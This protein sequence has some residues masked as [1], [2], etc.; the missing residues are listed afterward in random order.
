MDISKYD[1]LHEI[2]RHG[3]FVVYR[4]CRR[5]DRLPVLLQAPYRIPVALADREALERQFELIGGLVI[6]GI[7]KVYDLVRDNDRTYLVFEDAGFTPL[8]ALLQRGALDLALF[9]K[10]A[11]GLCSIV[12]DLHRRQLTHGA[13]GTGSVLVDPDSG[14]VQLLNTGLVPSTAVE[15]GRQASIAPAAYMSP[16]QTGRM[17]RPVDYRTDLY[18]LGITLYEALTAGRPFTSDDSLELIHAHIARTPTA[19]SALNPTVPEQLSRIVLKLLAKAAEHR[20]Q[21][22]P[23][24]KHD[25]ER[26]RE[27][28]EAT[29]AIAAFPPGQQD[30]PGRFLISQK[31]YGRDREVA[32]LLRAFE[33]TCEGPAALM[34]VSGYSGIG[35]TSLIHELYKPIVRQRGYFISGKFDQV[36][37]NIP[38]SGFTQA[39][40]GLV[41]QLLTESEDR[42]AQWRVRLS[43]AL[44]SNGGVLADV[45]PEVELILGRQAP[46]PPLDPAEAS[47]RFGYVFQSFVSALAQPEHPLVVFLDD[48]QWVDAATL[49]LL[50]ALLTGPDV[51]H[52]LIIGAYRDNEVDAGHL[53][54]RAIDRLDA[55]G[56]HLSRLSLA[57]LALPDLSSF[58]CDTL[59]RERPSIEPLA[60]LIQSKTDGNPFFVIQFL[61]T[62]EQEGHFTFAGERAGW[63]FDMAALAAAGMTDNVVD[64]MTRKIRRLSPSAQRVVTLAACVGNQF[65]W[66]TFVTVSRQSP[67]EAATGLAE[68][69][70]AG[71]VQ[72]LED[73]SRPAGGTASLYAFIHDRVQQA[74]YGLIPDEQKKP[75]HLDVGRL[76]LA[77]FDPTR[78]DD[79]IFTI[80]NHLNTGSDLITSAAERLSLAELNLSGGRKAKTSAAY[81]AAVE[82]S[83]KGVALLQ[84]SEWGSHYDLAF[85]LHL[86]RA[87]CLYLAGNFDLAHTAF[88]LPLEHAA[89]PLDRAQVHSLRIRL[90]ENQSRWADAV[91]AARDGLRLFDIAFPEDADGKQTALDREVGAVQ[92][93]LGSRA[94]ASLV[95]LPEMTDPDMQMVM[96]L[97]TS[98]WAPAYISG[99][100]ILARLI[101]AEMVRLSLAYGNTEDSA[102]GYVTH[103]IT[104]GPIRRDYRSAYEWG[105]LALSVNRRFGDVKRRAKI[106][107]QF[108]AHVN[109]WRRPFDTCIPHA[110]EAYRSGLESGDFAYAGYGA[111]TEAWSAWLINRDID[112]FVREFLPTLA[113]LEKTKMGDFWVAHR[114]ILNWA[115]ALEGRTSA[116]LSLSDATFD[117][118]RF[119]QK[120]EA[121]APFFLTFLYTAKLHLSVLYEDYGLA[122]TAAAAA[123]QAAVTGTIWPVLIDF[124]GGLAVAGIFHSASEEDQ[125]RY[126]TQLLTVQQSLAELA[127]ACPEN[128][129]GFALLISAEILRLKASPEEATTLYEEAIAWARQTS[130]LQQAALANDLCARMWL[131]QEDD[132]RATPFVRAAYQ[133]YAEW[134]ASAKLAHLEERYGRLLPGSMR[135][136]V[137]IRAPIGQTTRIEETDADLSTVLKVAH[138]IAVEIE[139]GGLLRKLMKLALEN[140][141]AQRGAFLHERDGRLV[142]EAAADADR[143]LV[144]VGPLVSLDEAHDLAVTVVRYVH[145]TRQ[146]VVIAN[147]AVDERFAGDPYVARSDAKSILCVP[148]GHQGRLGGILYLENSLTTDA[149]TP[150]RIAMMRILAAQTAISLETARLYDDM[151]DEVGRRTAA[152]RALRDALSE[153]EALKNRLEAENVYLQE[154]IQTQHNFNEIVGNSPPLVEALRQVERVAPTESTVLIVGETGSGKE[155]FARAVHSRSLRRNRPLV[156]V[157]CGAI[158]PGLV[159]SELFGHVKGAFTGAIEKRIGRFE[160]AHGGTIFLDEIGDLPLDAQVKLLRVLQEQEFEPVGSSRT[161]R[162]SVRV[163]AATNRD[164]DQAVR[165]GRFRTDLLYRL[166][167]FPIEVPPLRQRASDIGLLAGFFATA[168]ARRLGKPLQGFSARSMERMERYAWPGNI[169]ELQNVVE[170]AAILARGP[171]LEIESPLLGAGPGTPDVPA[172]VDA[173]PRGDSLDDVQRLHILEV[174]KITGGVVEGARGAATILGLHPNTLRSRMKRLGIATAS[175]HAS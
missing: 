58:L 80:I 125:R 102:Y 135:V 49:D 13:V 12:D 166:N 145:R 29:G 48:L 92:A 88:R 18:S 113:M 9:F 136:G 105:E 42:L 8:P 20:Y 38:Y 87:E 146:D 34:L 93:L 74:A 106:H 85:S 129:R 140:A 89:T 10:V 75:V 54:T 68:A 25:L 148:V 63:S 152:E 139:V 46:P 91:S 172:P 107:Q 40:R 83:E 59:H 81:G 144:T 143:E 61:K 79:R 124:W 35:K 5:S 153:V 62:L 78:P 96:R 147:A 95:E 99:D 77:D 130:N 159:E 109:L 37:R 15:A 174:L 108:Q 90:Y 7:P 23:G 127:D 51:R 160:L 26:C 101:S 133:A 115:L 55:S 168:I 50:H 31:L 84:P 72:E 30:L 67:G 17:N 41:W 73:P 173:P 110:R 134:G 117:E 171:L 111:A 24:L 6:A 103:A 164:L 52:L 155:L 4:G 47:N 150:G 32:E 112:R 66:E 104:I 114:I 60:A 70:Q 33:T 122:F 43:A 56:A 11:I 165:D 175:R 157:N 158:P 120:Y 19:P 14:E 131:R 64:L 36:V 154:E 57:P 141:G 121:T 28:F 97:L 1:V 132:D 137:S 21:S 71:L 156:K 16:E 123:T 27:Q 22:A 65:D 151:K 163:I 170:R 126:W 98:V 44:G 161:V 167:V 162:V 169:R 2:V 69:V 76:L 116:R 45:I 119:V 86:E 128:F 39:L 100:Q 53:L 82:Y 3:P 94:I 138:A 142:V 149:F 118:Q